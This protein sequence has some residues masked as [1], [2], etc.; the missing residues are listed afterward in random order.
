MA[1]LRPSIFPVC[2]NCRKGGSHASHARC[3]KSSRFSNKDNRVWIDVEK[4][5]KYCEGCKRS[6]DIS[7]S[8]KHCRCGAIFKGG[9]LWAG[10]QEEIG[11]Y[12]N[13]AWMQRLSLTKGSLE[14][15]MIGYDKC[16]FCGRWDKTRR[17]EFKPRARKVFISPNAGICNKCVTKYANKHSKLRATINVTC[18][19]CGEKQLRG[20][21]SGSKCICHYCLAAYSEMLLEQ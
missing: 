15:R 13:L 11:Q 16:S 1:I 19:F 5:T 18:S 12:Q 4:G 14:T 2:P 6:W 21:F 7:I 3:K 8:N 10:M 9:E 20:L 17:P